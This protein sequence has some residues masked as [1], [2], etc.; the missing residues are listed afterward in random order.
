[1][2]TLKEQLDTEEAANKKSADPKI[3]EAK[4]TPRFGNPYGAEYI[5]KAEALQENQI[6]KTE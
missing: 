3:T 6:D 4:K 1:M 5:K 2:S